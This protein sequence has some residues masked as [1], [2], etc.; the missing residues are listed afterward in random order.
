MTTDGAVHGTVVPGYERLREVFAGLLAAGRETGAALT[1]LRNG[2]PVAVLHG[3]WRDAARQHPWTD[4]T[5]V[6]VYSAGKP[7]IALA[8]LVL[9]DRG[10][11]SLDDPIARHWP[12]FAAN[13][14][15]D[16]TVRHA[17]THTAGLPGFPVPRDASA[18]GDWDLLCAD[19]AGAAP[20]WTPGTVAAEHALTYGHLL[21]ELVRRVDGRSPGR[22]VAEEIARPWGLDL[23]FGLDTADRDRCAELEYD[24]P[25]WPAR[26]LGTVGSV[27]ER[28]LR[29]PTGTRDLATVNG[30]AWRA[31]EVPAVNL[32]ATATGLARMYAGLLAGGVLDGHRLL[33]PALA[34][35]AVSA[36][37]DGPDL[38][39]EQRVVWGFGVQVEDDGTWGMGG[40]GGNAGWAD[41]ATGHAI[42]YVTRRLGDF[43]RVDELDSALP[44][45]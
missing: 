35:A 24:H 26:T 14:K 4:R 23:G 5:L 1:V 3:G 8:V 10:M 44:G 6:N 41:P 27:R 18:F 30:A 17:L 19:L 34:S 29:S 45:A 28:A 9:V 39:L 25:D 12:Q 15:G 16:T 36:Q 31:A 38:M 40:L 13:G 20:Q 43:D 2:E 37:H 42:G 22:F 11:L 32:H 33:D 7:L 21:G